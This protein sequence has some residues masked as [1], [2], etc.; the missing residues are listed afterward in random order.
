MARFSQISQKDLKANQ[1]NEAKFFA[2]SPRWAGTQNYGSAQ[3]VAPPPMLVRAPR[4]ALN[5]VPQTTSVPPALFVTLL[6][7]SKAANYKSPRNTPTP[8]LFVIPLV[9]ENASKRACV[10]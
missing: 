8:P 1:R 2:S 6:L 10:A 4:V 7:T 3:F 5:W 9:S